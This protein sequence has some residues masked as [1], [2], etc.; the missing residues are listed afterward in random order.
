MVQSPEGSCTGSK[1]TVTTEPPLTPGCPSS[2]NFGTTMIL[3]PSAAGPET[4][5]GSGV[6]A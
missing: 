3:Q 4:S 2:A 5:P 1:G 6:R